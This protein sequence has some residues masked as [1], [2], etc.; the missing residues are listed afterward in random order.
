MT[1]YGVR[2][3][4]LGEAPEVRVNRQVLEVTHL[5]D[6]DQIDIGRFSFLVHIKW[7]AE[8]RPLLSLT[9]DARL[10]N[11]SGPASNRLLSNAAWESEPIRRRRI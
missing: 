1:S 10:S 3:R 9:A 7:P 11:R 6:Q 8:S 4:H 2:L 5:E